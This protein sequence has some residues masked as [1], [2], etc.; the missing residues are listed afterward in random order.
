MTL[1]LT[2]PLIIASHNKGKLA[3]FDL[4]LSPLGLRVTSAAALD[5]P[6]PEETGD[7]FEANSALKALA[8]AHATGLTALADDSGM[9]V[10]ALDG[11]PGIYSAR[12]AGEQ[13]DFT[14][15][16]A[17]VRDALRARGIDPEGARAYFVCVLTLAD[18]QG[19]VCHV[20]GEVHGRL[21]A[22][23]RGTLGFGYDPMFI[24]DG[25]D[26]TF[27]EMDP[28]AK[29]AMSHRALALTQ[30]KHYLSEQTACPA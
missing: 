17:R 11:A 28:A 20:R 26:I 19:H 9:C 5:L 25:H 1:A 18:A 3:E 12:W 15:A 8:A 21:T 4:M 14:T 27:G 13:K 23:P 29:H 16:M 2:S 10:E 24:P 6:E 22:T 30:L 7:S